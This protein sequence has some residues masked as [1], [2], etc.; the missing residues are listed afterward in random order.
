MNFPGGAGAPE[1]L[2]VILAVARMRH[3]AKTSTACFGGRVWESNPPGIAGNP[4][5]I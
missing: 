1:S 5:Q 4:Y 3:S 2:V